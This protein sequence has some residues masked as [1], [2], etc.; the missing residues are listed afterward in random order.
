ME[1]PNFFLFR[2]VGFCCR[3]FGGR[4]FGPGGSVSLIL[5]SCSVFVARVAILSRIF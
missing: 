1:F 3:V 2:A 4:F 5:S